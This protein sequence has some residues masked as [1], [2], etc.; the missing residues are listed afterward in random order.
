MR[1]VT[2]FDVNVIGITLSRSHCACSAAKLASLDTER[3]A[4]ARLQGWE[5]FD[6]KVDRIF[7][8]EA[9]DAFKR[10]VTRRSSNVPERFCPTTAGC[11]STAYS[12]T[13][14]PLARARHQSDDERSALLSVP[15]PGD[16]SRRPD[17]G[18]NDIYKYSQDAGFRLADEYLMP[19]HYVRTLDIWAD[20]LRDQRDRAIAVQSEEVYER[21]LRYLTGCADLFRRG[22]SNVGQ[23]LLTK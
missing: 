2:Q 20:N 7:T 12:P 3:R 6:E 11:C 9:F 4:E 15:G 17:G 22:I 10:S 14:N 21:Y 16:L 13:P 19:E 8:I 1:A 18:L 5:E 23:F